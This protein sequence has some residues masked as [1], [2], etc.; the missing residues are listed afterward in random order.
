M[1]V[2][3]LI[4]KAGIYK[5]QSIQVVD[6]SNNTVEGITYKMPYMVDKKLSEK[7]TNTMVNSF[8]VSQEGIRIHVTLK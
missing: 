5:G 4:K 1:K 3:D 6:H 2:G 7:L 8:N